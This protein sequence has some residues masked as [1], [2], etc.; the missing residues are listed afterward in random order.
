MDIGTS[1]HHLGKLGEAEST[2][3]QTLAL[4]RKIYTPDHP[5][6]LINM[7][8]LA[9]LLFEEK[10]FDDADAVLTEAIALGQKKLAPLDTPMDTLVLQLAQVRAKQK[11]FDEAVQLAHQFHSAVAERFGQR[12]VRTLSAVVLVYDNLLQADRAAEGVAMIESIGDLPPE[13]PPDLRQRLLTCAGQLYLATGNEAEARRYAA[14]ARMSVQKD[15][16]GKER[17]TPS[18]KLLESQLHIGPTTQTAT[19][20]GR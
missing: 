1:L 12:S 10:K 6:V 19:S 18:L 9:G 15:S 7:N 14:L 20:A 3:R 8:N 11:R 16:Q 4:A 13:V 5:T 17:V 2:L